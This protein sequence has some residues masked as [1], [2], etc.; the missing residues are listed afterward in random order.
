[1]NFVKDKFWLALLKCSPWSDEISINI[2]I[3]SFWRTSCN[4][5]QKSFNIGAP[6]ATEAIQTDD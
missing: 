1:M 3:D 6:I 2:G 4:L 5:T